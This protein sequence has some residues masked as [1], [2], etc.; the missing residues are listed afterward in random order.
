M[1]KKF[2]AFVYCVYLMDVK[3]HYLSNKINPAVLLGRLPCVKIKYEKKGQNFLEE[4]NKVFTDKTNGISIIFAL[5]LAIGLIGIILV[6]SFGI[7]SKVFHLYEYVPGFYFVLFFG[8]AMLICYFISFR[9]NKYLDYFEKFEK[10]TVKEKRRNIIFSFL[11]II[12]VIVY[13][14]VGLMCC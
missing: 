11:A 14:F 6:S 10:W 1:E 9:K 3:L 2:N 7:I 8:I 12:A 4:V 5:G 13:F